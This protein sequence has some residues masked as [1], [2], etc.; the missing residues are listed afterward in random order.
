MKKLFKSRDMLFCDVTLFYEVPG[1]VQV[2]Q[3]LH[4]TV[5]EQQLANYQRATVE[6]KWSRREEEK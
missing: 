3:T 2:S 6:K 5:Q 4:Q 1:G